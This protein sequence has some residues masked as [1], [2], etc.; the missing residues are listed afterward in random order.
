MQAPHPE[1][2]QCRLRMEPGYLVDHGHGV[3]YPAAWV[4]GVPEWSRWFGLKVK[5]KDKVPVT[6]FR[7]PRCGRLDSFGRPG[8]W[9]S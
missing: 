6:T 5:R 8:A 3:A 7:C 1:C 2:P 9:P 4:A